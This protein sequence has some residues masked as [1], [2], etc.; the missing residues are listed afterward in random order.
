MKSN[1][2]EKALRTLEVFKTGQAPLSVIEISQLTGDAISSVQRNTYTLQSLGYLER[3]PDGN[4]YVLG[5]RS[6]HIGFGYLRINK[7]L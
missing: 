4:R 7:F 1:A 3:E 2:L 6:L 5:R